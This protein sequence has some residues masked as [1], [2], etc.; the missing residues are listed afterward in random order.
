MGDEE[1][2]LQIKVDELMLAQLT[3]DL[4][5]QEE[6]VIQYWE[7]RTESKESLD[8]IISLILH[9]SQKMTLFDRLH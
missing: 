9:N 8:I 5:P 6:R 2:K 4:T 1:K 3:R 7:K